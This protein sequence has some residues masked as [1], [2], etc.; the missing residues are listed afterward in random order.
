MLPN[1]E[2]PTTRQ[3][4]MYSMA[5]TMA[6]RDIK[7]C[8]IEALSNLCIPTQT[9]QANQTTQIRHLRVLLGGGPLGVAV[10]LCATV[11]PDCC[12]T[13]T[14][15]RSVL[16]H[17][18]PT[19]PASYKEASSESRGGGGGGIPRRWATMQLRWGSRG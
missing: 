9:T 11:Y 4:R 10:W 18:G 7:S 14:G 13:A 6:S 5:R 8:G 19:I 1:P 12:T 3:R 16:V 2:T 15:H 17:A